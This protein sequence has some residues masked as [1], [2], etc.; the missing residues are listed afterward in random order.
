MDVDAIVDV[1]SYA[2]YIGLAERLRALGLDEDTTPG[3]PLCRWRHGQLIVDVMQRLAHC[4]HARSRLL[5]REVRHP[6]APAAVQRGSA[7]VDMAYHD[8]LSGRIS[9]DF[10]TRK[11]AD[12]ERELECVRAE[13]AKHE[14]A[15]QQVLGDGPQDSRTRENGLQV[16]RFA[17]FGRTA[18]TAGNAAIELR[19]RARNPHAYIQKAVRPVGERD[20]NEGMAGTQGFEPQ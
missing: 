2:K 4:G 7:E 3:A 16:V 6:A 1:T 20:R 9:D 18:K 8:R 13:L 19:L 5:K 11:S 10:W 12:W 17:E 14:G 15:S